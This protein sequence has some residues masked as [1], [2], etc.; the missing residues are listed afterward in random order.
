MDSDFQVSREQVKMYLLSQKDIPWVT[1]RVVIAEVNYGGR[2]TDEKDV[3]LISALLR[4]YFC[5]E[6]LQKNFCFMGL[7]AYY[8]PAEGT[9]EQTREYVKTLPLD[10][11]PRVFGL[12]SNA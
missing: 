1:L 9:L 6:M 11:D 5:P 4:G 7:A 2:V 12:H 3:R 10:E 8:P